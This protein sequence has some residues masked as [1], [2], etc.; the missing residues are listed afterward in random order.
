M[1]KYMNTLAVILVPAPDGMSK[2]K[3]EPVPLSQDEVQ[4]PK[5][6]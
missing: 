6:L 3:F 2:A 4:P 5:I 1:Y